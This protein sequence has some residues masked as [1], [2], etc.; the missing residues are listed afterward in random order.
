MNFEETTDDGLIDYVVGRDPGP[1]EAA[2][3]E[4]QRRAMAVQRESNTIQKELIAAIESSGDCASVQTA[5]VIR[6]TNT[7]KTLTYVLIGLGVVQTAL[8]FWLKG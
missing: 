4:M 8:M 6:L 5:E 2:S 1:R 3:M 7:L